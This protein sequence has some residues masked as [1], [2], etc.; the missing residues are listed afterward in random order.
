MLVQ[1]YFCIAEAWKKVFLRIYNEV[2][3]VSNFYDPSYFA[4]E[5]F[6]CDEKFMEIQTDDGQRSEK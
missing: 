5:V 1:R 4:I 3:R 6:E 2:E